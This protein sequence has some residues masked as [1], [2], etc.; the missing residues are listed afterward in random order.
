MTHIATFGGK[1]TANCKWRGGWQHQY[2]LQRLT[3]G[4]LRSATSHSVWG[5]VCASAARRRAQMCCCL[6]HG[7]RPTCTRANKV[8]RM[9]TPFQPNVGISGIDLSGGGCQ[10]LPLA[11]RYSHPSLKKKCDFSGCKSRFSPEGR[12]PGELRG[13]ARL[14][15]QGTQVEGDKK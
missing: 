6:C 2:A 4:V 1:N 10:G 11:I 9:S 12:H 3:V 15:T 14:G 13:N 8:R 5:L 7:V